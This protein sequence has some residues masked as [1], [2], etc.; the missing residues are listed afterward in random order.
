M[1]ERR[2]SVSGLTDEE[3][4]RSSIAFWMRG[5]HRL[6]GGSR[7]GAH[8][9]SGSGGPG[10]SQSGRAR[11]DMASSGTNGASPLHVEPHAGGGGCGKTFFLH[12]LA[13]F[14]MLLMAIRPRRLRRARACNGGPG[15]PVP[16][17]LVKFGDGWREGGCVH[18]H[19]ASSIGG[20]VMWRIWKSGCSIRFASMVAQG[21]F[22]FGLAVMIHLILLS[23]PTFNWFDGP[24]MP[25]RR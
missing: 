6:H 9:M 15:Y 14:A 25:T 18:L 4:S 17:A 19:V 13:A 23:T 1:A 2:G 10:C 21:V 11:T 22:L 7:G 12:L 3:A 20:H 5:F 24:S 16:R 8:P